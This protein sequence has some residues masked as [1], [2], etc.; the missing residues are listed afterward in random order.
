MIGLVH[1]TLNPITVNRRSPCST[2]VGYCFGLSDKDGMDDWIVTHCESMSEI[3][4]EVPVL[5][6]PDLSSRRLTRAV[7]LEED[8]PPEDQSGE[9]D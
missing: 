2:L 7:T 3:S 4:V 5:L 6:R 8:H 1:W 9:H